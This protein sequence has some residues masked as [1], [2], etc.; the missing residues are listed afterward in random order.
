[1]PWKDTFR[2]G[3]CEVNVISSSY[4]TLN[5]KWV[6]DVMFAFQFLLCVDYLDGV[7]VAAY[8]TTN[9]LIVFICLS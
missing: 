8:N 4:A 6:V 2:F 9:L 3:I 5:M 1:M 7:A